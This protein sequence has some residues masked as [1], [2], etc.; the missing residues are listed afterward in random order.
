MLASMI[1]RADMSMLK[2]SDVGVSE[3]V[4]TGT[5]TLL[6]ADVQGST[7]LWETQPETMTAAVAQL[8]R[9][10]TDLVSDHD[11]V[12]PV[13]QG[14]GDSFV[15]AFT[16]ASDAVACALALQR[17]PL[18]PIRLRIGVHTGE[19]RL[20][21][22]GNYVGPTINRTAR[23]RE[24]AHGGQTVLSGTTSD[25]VA[26]LLPDGGWLSDLGTH[27]LRDLPR[28]ERVVQLCHA[29]LSNEFPPLRAREEIGVQ[30]LPAQL[31]SFVG[32]VDDMAQVRGLMDANR[33]VTLTGAGGVGK[34]RLATQ[35][36]VAVVE[37]YP[38]GVWYVDLAPIT[39]PALVAITVAR[40]LGLPDQP[41]RSTVDTIVRF[42]ADR[43][44]LVVLDNCEH[45]LDACATLIDALLGA[46][47]ALAMLATSREPIAVAG[48][49]TWRVPPLALDDDAIELFTDR[50]RR[51]RPDFI[52]SA[53][54]AAAVSE[55]CHRLDGMPLAIEL[56]AARVRALSLTEIV[57]GLH[58]RFRLLTGGSRTAVRRQQTLRASVDWSHGLLTD[59]ER[60]LFRRLAV[61]AGGFDL[62]G[63]QAI[64]VDG[65]VHRYEVVDLL[66]LLVDKSLLIAENTA[67]RTRYRLLETVRQYA[68]EKLGESGE[69]DTLRARHRDH[70]TA[71][72]A[73]LDAPSV[74]GHERRLNQT[75]I[76]MDNLRAAFAW[77]RENADTDHSLLL[78]S[79]L[80][81]LWRARGRL[82]E[83]QA[84]F[85]AALTDYEAR[86]GEADPAVYARALADRAFM[87]GHVG[88]TDRLDQ[89]QKA[90]AMARDIDDPALLVRALTACGGLAAYNADVAR[91]LLAE[92]VDLARSMG[93]KW[94]LAETLAWQAYAALM[95]GGDPV[96]ARTA[97]EEAR[98]LADEMGDGFVS[99]ICG[100]LLGIAHHFQGDL[101]AALALADGVVSESDV[102]HDT[103]NGCCGELVLAH[104]LA[105][106]GDT[107]AARAAAQVSLNVA[108][109]V[110]PV[111]AGLAHAALAVANLAA[112]DV[113]AAEAASDSATRSFGP[114]EV[115]GIQ[116][117]NVAAQI[118]C[119]RGDL[120][121]ARS[122]VDG[123][124]SI[125][126]GVHRAS[127]LT[128]R[129]RIAIAQGDPEQAE[130]NAHDALSLAA[131]V[132]ARLEVPDTLECLARVVGDGGSHH[133]AARLC[134]AAEAIRGRTG[135]V[136]FRIYDADH[137]TTVT[138]LRDA[139]GDKA[140]EAAWTEGSAT[141]I[142]EAIAYA[143]RGRGER[144]RPSSG[145][146]SLTPTELD[147]VGL[148][149]EGLSNKD[150]AARLFVS[151]RTVQTHLTHVYTKLCLA[152]RVQLAQEAARHT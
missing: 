47:P 44:M 132:G 84:W 152:S 93:D 14:E 92:A 59:P 50:A 12:R 144:K 48:E 43:R 109:E 127:A 15:V 19:V 67:G 65:E 136:R 123:A 26:D 139:L 148:V 125:T 8:D 63:A 110:S 146:A 57:D 53:D 24:L 96:A 85:D 7:Q 103:L 62:D 141:S 142:T 29:D 40:A 9:T 2:W 121:T 140:F 41:G 107:D 71:R 113:T 133:E 75:D 49:Q 20:R 151:P 6:L 126:R 80:H 51:A 32:R 137:E 4:P 135:A 82:Q 46:C 118:A 108:V 58:D 99:R 27:R 3:L 21:D 124:V 130:R 97:G 101:D 36:A 52:I 79:S 105:Q 104:A 149:S 145:W 39:D 112:G 35:V 131:G 31:T 81:P 106:R 38:G 60:V 120:D 74:A 66:T 25:L 90:L 122:L 77:S 73:E 100:W 22:E 28:P 54:D 116:D 134:G 72:A 56:A 11:G 87:D 18:A 45:L 83:G 30:R 17:A 23:L 16:R 69:A 94:M 89:A 117:P 95:G 34:T 78:A 111:H 13:E 37:G 86:S 76:E 68:Q 10:L 128:T 114:S 42:I 102:A 138:T 143:Q 98:E 88:I 33:L 129:A 1:E 55:I 150:I 119:T 147:V 5:V 91:P 64:T 70:Y 61:F 115:A